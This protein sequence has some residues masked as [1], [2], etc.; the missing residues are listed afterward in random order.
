MNI[1]LKFSLD[2]SKRTYSGSSLDTE[3]TKKE[4]PLIQKLLFERGHRPSRST[5]QLKNSK[6]FGSSLDQGLDKPIPNL[7]SHSKRICKSEESAIDDTAALNLARGGSSLSSHDDVFQRDCKS[8]NLAHI[9]ILHPT[10]V[11]EQAA[12]TPIVPS[13]RLQT[14]SNSISSCEMALSSPHDGDDSSYGTSSVKGMNRDDSLE[15]VK[16]CETDPLL[17]KELEERQNANCKEEDEE[18]VDEKKPLLD[19]F[20]NES[21]E[22][23]EPAEMRLTSSYSGQSTLSRMEKSARRRCESESRYI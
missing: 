17:D 3:A 20:M 12:M 8:K 16:S 22:S 14:S 6:L 4:M 5:S 13:T 11:S 1:F 18:Q 23:D 19:E 21:R 7:D 2:Q 9:E 10:S 15:Q